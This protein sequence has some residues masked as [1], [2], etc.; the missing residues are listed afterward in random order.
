MGNRPE[1]RWSSCLTDLQEIEGLEDLTS[2]M[3]KKRVGTLL[4]NFKTQYS[5][6]YVPVEDVKGLVL[7]RIVHSRV[8]A[9]K[10][11]KEIRKKRNIEYNVKSSYQKKIL[12]KRQ[13]EKA[14][15]K[16][17]YNDKTLT[18]TLFGSSRAIKK[19]S[20]F[21]DE[22]NFDDYDV[23]SA[24]TSSGHKKVK[25]EDSQTL[26]QKE[27]DLA[28]EEMALRKKE[29]E[30]QKEK[31]KFEQEERMKMLELLKQKPE[32]LKDGIMFVEDPVRNKDLDASVRATSLATQYG[33][34]LEGF[35]EAQKKNQGDE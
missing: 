30:L 35:L 6:G 4:E 13:A 24:S 16:V 11:P 34:L 17:K 29:L 9:G 10:E 15:W 2:R 33:L 19:E 23:G 18:R 21:S 12:K 32:L 31:L 25:M 3:L 1:A 27:I 7:Q 26:W 20:E 28:R 8:A 22:D 14:K 5:E